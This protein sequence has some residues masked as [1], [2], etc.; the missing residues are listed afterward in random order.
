MLNLF[1]SPPTVTVIIVGNP[2]SEHSTVNKI[3]HS[4]AVEQTFHTQIV[5]C[6]YRHAC[7]DVAS[8]IESVIEKRKICS[9][10][11][12]LKVILFDYFVIL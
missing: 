3:T 5:S 1:M 2:S 8:T 11:L 9:K 4:C 10:L 7:Q 6:Y 12:F